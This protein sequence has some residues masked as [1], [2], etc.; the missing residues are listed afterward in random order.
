MMGKNLAATLTQLIEENTND[1]RQRSDIVSSMA[2]AAGIDTSTVSSI[3]QGEISCPPLNRLAGFADALGVDVGTLISSGRRDGCSYEE[4]EKSYNKM[5]GTPLFGVTSFQEL[6]EL[7]RAQES[8]GA[9]AELTEMFSMIVAN[10]AQDSSIEDKT[11]AINFVTGEF[12]QR[13]EAATNKIQ[14]KDS[15]LLAPIKRLFS[16]SDTPDV[17]DDA[18][19]G[20]MAEVEDVP[21]LPGESTDKADANSSFSVWKDKNGQYRWL[22]VY[23]N[24]FRDDDNPPEIIS[25]QSHKSYVELVDDGVV[26]YPDLWHWHIPGTR[27]GV[28]DMVDYSDGFAV[29]AGVV[30]AGHEKEAEALSKMGDIRVSHGMPS[31]FIVRNAGDPSVIDFHITTEISPLP[32]WAAANKMTDFVV[33]NKEHNN[34]ALTAEKKA[35]LQKAG[36][37][38]GVISELETNLAAKAKDAKDAGIEH[39]ETSADA[40]KPVDEVEEKE[41]GAI[42]ETDEPTSAPAP[43]LTA[44]DI[45]G[46]FSDALAPVMQAVSD[47]QSRM[48]GIESEVKELKVSDDEKIAKAAQMTPAASLQALIA[49][50]ILG[51]PDAQLD[52]RSAL[53]KSKPKE[54]AAPTDQVTGVSFVDNLIANTQKQEA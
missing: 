29:A 35:Y 20:F 27:W 46:V 50:N 54:A 7:Q 42:V 26:D 4:L 33:L 53:A 34:M 14:N 39:K 8:S 52:G 5:M 13:V 17:G 24:Q 37:D 9:V 11:G 25:E 21:D 19:D 3:L 23:S 49:Q 2:S 47:L 45:A 30:D 51:S 31:R 38:E 36:L 6:E 48:G 41:D 28:A 32:G 12:S 44:E 40:V 43:S 15:G 22:A 18:D 10:I 1:R 16:K